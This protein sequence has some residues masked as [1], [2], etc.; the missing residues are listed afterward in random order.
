VPTREIALARV[1]TQLAVLAC[2]V[3]LSLVPAPAAGG[4]A[5][6]DTLYVSRADAACSDSGPGS[7]AR[8]FCTIQAAAA[9]VRAGET[10]RV[11]AGVYREN[12]VVVTSGTQKRPIVFEATHH[13]AVVVRGQANGFTI[14]HRQWVTVDGFVV[15]HTRSYGI[16]VLNSSFITISGNHVH[17]AGRR[18]KGLARSGIYLDHT[19]E[20][21]VTRNVAGHNTYAGIQLADGSTGDEV[22]GN[23]TFANASG[24][25]RQAPG[26]RVNAAPGNTIDRN[27][28]FGNEDSGIECYA[29]AN[30]TLVY[31]NVSYRN[32]DHGI[33][34][35]DCTG[36]R[37]IANSVYDNLTAGINV[38]AGSTDTV[39]ADNISV[40]NGITS[41][42]T[43]S[44]IRVERGS[45]AGTTLTSDIVYLSTL[46]T[47][48]IWNSMPYRTLA[49]FQDA[50][51][52]E[53][54]GIEADPR[55]AD[56]GH[57]NF[58]L[59]PGSPAIDSADS[60]V[61]GWPATDIMGH[62]RVDDPATPNTGTG[63]RRYADRGAYEY[64]PPRG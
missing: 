10:V 17:Y 2:L 39:V 40:D 15:T 37:V 51:G 56:P 20:S 4:V 24:Y 6:P 5:A 57:G 1:K 14:S 12:V 53:L 25:V 35:H 21:L 18:A 19:S 30:R 49:A 36:N 46:A 60:A 34:T 38:E 23:T 33:D 54:H 61:S 3:L 28:S 26:I 9:N 22:R 11:A 42:R 47:L 59:E 43:H 64:R 58:E 8:P 44:D 62:G 27:R 52:Q 29:G 7:A 50:T 16:W 45:T 48:V 32:G 41:P 13:G 31:D 63:P 55:W